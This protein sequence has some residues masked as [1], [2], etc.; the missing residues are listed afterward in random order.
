MD[1][2]EALKSW[3]SF[4]R[5]LL[6]LAKARAAGSTD[7]APARLES[8]QWIQVLCLTFVLERSTKAA[9]S[10]Q[11]NLR[12]KDLQC[13]PVSFSWRENYLKRTLCGRR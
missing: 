9:N 13:L 1:D 7:A 2:F 8:Q 12:A 10:N 5:T 3:V 6:S 4:W 11:P